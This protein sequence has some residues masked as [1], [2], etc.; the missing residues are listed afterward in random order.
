MLSEV[1]R[2]DVET[3]QRQTGMD[4][5][6]SRM[7][8]Y[9]AALVAASTVDVYAGFGAATL[10]LLGAVRRDGGHRG[11]TTFGAA[12]HAAVSLRFLICAPD[13]SGRS[14]APPGLSIVRAWSYQ[15]VASQTV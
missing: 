8:P 13:S 5:I 10:T 4:I 6:T 12:T 9:R 2:C 11:E 7:L 14:A 1:M 15:L 3:K